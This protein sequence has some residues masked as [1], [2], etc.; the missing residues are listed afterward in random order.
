MSELFHVQEERHEPHPVFQLWQRAR[1][2]AVIRD[3]LPV[4]VVTGPEW[5]GRLVVVHEADLAALSGRTLDQ[6]MGY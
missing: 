5:S 3:Q 1:K 6:V 2:T 4:V